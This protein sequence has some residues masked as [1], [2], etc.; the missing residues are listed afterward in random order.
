MNRQQRPILLFGAGTVVLLALGGGP[1]VTQELQLFE[2]VEQPESV[3]RPAATGAGRGRGP[4]TSGE[5]MF[6]LVGTSRLG[7]RYTVRLRSSGGEVVR[8]DYHPS[9]LGEHPGRPGDAVDIPGYP[10]FRL[11]AVGSRHVVVRHPEHTPCAD[12]A[13]DGVSCSVGDNSARLSLATAQP[14]ERAGPE[15]G[16]SG[17]EETGETDNSGEADGGE[18]PFTAALR[19]ARNRSGEDEAALRARAQRFERRRI[20]EDE[21]PDGYRVVNTPFG[22]RLVPE[23]P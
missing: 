9:R 15:N 10:G 4:D 23:A 16:G 17:A 20:S 6:T 11:S 21:V 3:E 22:D 19:A 18:N 2:P 7:D 14:V 12:F 13:D 5:P 8:V 1:A